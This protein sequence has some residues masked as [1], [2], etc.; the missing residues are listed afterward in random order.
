MFKLD[1]NG[2]F[3]FAFVKIL[4]GYFSYRQGKGTVDIV[5]PVLKEYKDAAAGITQGIQMTERKSKKVEAHISE[6]KKLVIA[7][8]FVM[9]ITMGYAK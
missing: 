8:I 6:I 4:T 1:Q 7:T 2:L 9:A 5:K 3:F